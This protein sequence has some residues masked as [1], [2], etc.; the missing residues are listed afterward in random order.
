MPHSPIKQTGWDTRPSKVMSCVMWRIH[1]L[2]GGYKCPIPK[3]ATYEFFEILFTDPFCKAIRRKPDKQWVTKP[4]HK[5]REMC[6]L[7]S[8]GCRSLDLT[9]G[10]KLHYI[11]SGSHRADWRRFNTL[12]LYHLIHI[13]FV[14]FIP[15]EQFRAVKRKAKVQSTFET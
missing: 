1:V 9:K 14:K 5:H 4:V 6:G 11:I 2:C 8:A 7:S 13:M 15:A 12:Q 10:H 3:D